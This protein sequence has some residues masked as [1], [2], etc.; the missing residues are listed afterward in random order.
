MITKSPYT[1]LI[2]KAYLND[3]RDDGQGYKTV[4]SVKCDIQTNDESKEIYQYTHTVWIWNDSLVVFNGTT[5]TWKAYL[6]VAGRIKI[7]E[8]MY[9]SA[10]VFDKQI[11][12]E[13]KLYSPS[14]MGVMLGVDINKL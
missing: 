2:R 13:I 1:G 5:M 4:L 7:Q 11:S 12:G 6:A 9:F 10:D 14:Q 3:I 8:G